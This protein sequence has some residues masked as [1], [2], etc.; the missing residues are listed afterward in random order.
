[1]SNHEEVLRI[2]IRWKGEFPQGT[3][4]AADHWERGYGDLEWRGMISERVMPWYWTAYTEGQV[5]GFGV[6]T[7]A[8]A[9]CF[10]QADAS[11]ITL[12]LDVRS[13]GCGVILNGRELLAAVI[14]RHEGQAGETLLESM[15]RFCR[16]M[17]EQPLLPDEPVYGGNNW[18]YAYGESSHREILSDTKRIA[19][20]APSSGP[21]PYMIIDDGWQICHSRVCN[22]GPWFA[23]NYKFPDM[24]A[25]AGEMKSLGTRPGL[26]MR[27]LLTTMK[28][29]EE[30]QLNNR[31]NVNFP[32]EGTIMDPSIPG[33]LDQ[34]REDVER[35]AAWGYELIKHDFSTFDLFGKWGFE[36]GSQPTD[37]GWSFADQ[38]RTTAEIV[39]DL[40]RAI[41]EASGNAI[42]IGCNTIGHLAA[43]YV[44]LQRT[45]DDTSGKVWE[46]TRKYGVNTLAFRMPQHQAFFAADADCVGITEQIPW[47]L[48]KQWLHLL[49]NSGTP[50]FV[51]AH[52]AAIG[53]EQEEALAEAFRAASQPLPAAVPLDWLENSCPARWR[54]G[55][56]EV[57]YDWFDL[58]ETATLKHGTI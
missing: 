51:S 56:E 33:V 19:A 27:P 50:L 14:I 52:P 34:I 39:T 53:R 54:L 40:Y 32:F 38:S 9:L 49:A 57:R 47:H 29:P 6:Q 23:G 20:L 25:L 22:G 35:V 44:H 3:H 11:G 48:N 1:M 2:A 18:Y 17:C 45:G 4:I 37:D 24:A 30:W 12:W 31:R 5:Y 26:W 15:H 58:M 28:T 36:M 21:R 42:I 41:R 7:G 10:W 16:V 13:G 43:G 8:A 55:G 46:R